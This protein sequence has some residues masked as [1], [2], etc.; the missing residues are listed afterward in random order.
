[1]IEYKPGEMYLF[2]VIGIFIYNRLDFSYSRV[3]QMIFF[4]FSVSAGNC[5]SIQ[6][7]GSTPVGGGL[8]LLLCLSLAYAIKHSH[9]SPGN[10]DEI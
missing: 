7:G 9:A 4:L 6:P 8:T 3:I 2:N 10:E 1:L 5:T